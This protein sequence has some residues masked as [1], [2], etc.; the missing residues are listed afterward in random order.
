MVKLDLLGPE[1]SSPS[2]PKVGADSFIPSEHANLRASNLAFLSFLPYC[3][4][5]SSK[6][7]HSRIQVLGLIEDLFFAASSMESYDVQIT[8]YI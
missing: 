4:A 1:P 3:I 7:S 8:R 6:F 2:R 5:T